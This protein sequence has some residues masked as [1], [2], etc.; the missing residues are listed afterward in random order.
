MIQH[1]VKHH[2]VLAIQPQ[3]HGQDGL[4]ARIQQGDDIAVDL[5][6]GRLAAAG[7]I[8]QGG[9]ACLEVERHQAI[10]AH[11]DR[12]LAIQGLARGPFLQ[13][14]AVVDAKTGIDTVM[15]GDLEV[16]AGLV[17][18]N[19][20]GGNGE[21][22]GELVA[23]LMIQG[24]IEGDGD[25]AIDIAAGLAGGQLGLEHL[26][27][28]A[29]AIQVVTGQQAITAEFES[30]HM[31]VAADAAAIEASQSSGLIGEGGGI[32]KQWIGLMAHDKLALP[33]HG[34]RIGEAIFREADGGYG[35]VRRRAVHQVDGKIGAHQISVA[36][37]VLQG[38][39]QVQAVL[40]VVQTLVP[41]DTIAAVIGK[42][43]GED[44]DA[45]GTGGQGLAACLVG[46]R[47]AVAGQA[48]LL[49]GALIGAK[50]HLQIAIQT[51][52][53]VQ[54][55]G[56]AHRALGE[57]RLGQGQ[58]IALADEGGPVDHPVARQI[59]H[60]GAHLK[61]A[62]D[63]GQ[64]QAVQLPAT[65][66]AHQGAAAV[67]GL[68]VLADE[69]DGDA[70]PRLHV[71]GA[72]AQGDTVMTEDAV[73]IEIVDV[74]GGTGVDRHRQCVACPVAGD[75]HRIDA[76]II[77]AIGQGI[78]DG[79]LP[80]AIA[81]HGEHGHHGPAEAQGDGGARLPLTLQQGGGVPG[82]IVGLAGPC[83]ALIGQVER[84]GGDGVEQGLAGIDRLVAEA[85]DGM[86]M[87]GEGAVH[88][89]A[90]DV[91]K[92]G[93]PL[94][95]GQHHSGHCEA[96][97]ILINQGDGD[98]LPLL[99]VRDLAPDDEVHHLVGVDDVVAG[100]GLEDGDG[101]IGIHVLAIVAITHLLAGTL[102]IGVKTGL[103]QGGVIGPVD[104]DETGGTGACPH[105]AATRRGP[106]AGGGFG[107]D[108]R[109]V[110]PGADGLL[111]RLQIDMGGR[112]VRLAIEG[113]G[114]GTADP[115]ALLID[116]S[117]TI[118]PHLHPL[119]ITPQPGLTLAPGQHYLTGSDL[120]LGRHPGDCPGLVDN[121]HLSLHLFDL[122]RSIHSI[123][124]HT[125]PYLFHQT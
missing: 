54:G 32:R 11:I 56:G 45:P 71:R 116:A 81:V 67:E 122:S 4:A 109:G 78:W 99:H 86:G 124:F 91:A 69:G 65:I 115:I 23:A 42:G 31:T 19:L 96:V 59:R 125:A 123:I 53:G 98:G 121:E 88:Q 25:L 103:G 20:L 8:I 83:V 64:I 102:M 119:A 3:G 27:P 43:Q 100:L 34:R 55:S 57:I 21:P 48:E 73:G 120:P 47:R 94:V 38:K 108:G 76:K 22:E 110:D 112:L 26:D 84:D 80:V 9:L 10:A 93:G 77:G 41:D 113:Q 117:G 6:A 52:P 70:L 87:N 1:A 33:H 16:G 68:A 37:A 97:A 44:G 82:Q 75:V 50:A 5:I 18:V 118:G 15:D 79:V 46:E 89:L 60:L 7:E 105:H 106:G 49:E 85:I 61:G 29:I 95:A 28:L 62:L 107:K 92:I 13:A 30:Q 2:L 66:A 72:A 51:G 17:T 58:G 40:A 101:G 12:Q 90:G 111:Q 35:E 114:V 104:H 36:V 74:D 24:P 63:V 39:R 14:D